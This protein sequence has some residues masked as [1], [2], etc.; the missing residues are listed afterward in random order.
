MMK[1]RHPT[2]RV[3]RVLAGVALAMALVGAPA[4]SM[5]DEAAPAVAVDGTSDAAAHG[6]AH[7]DEAHG[8]E[9]HGDD[10]KKG[11]DPLVFGSAVI[12]FLLYLGLLTFVFRKP[13]AK[14]FADRRGAIASE[15]EAARA[16]REEAEA[17]LTE[18]KKKLADFDAERTRLLTEFRELGEQ[19][20]LRIVAEGEAEAARI[21]RDATLAAENDVR[22]AKAALESQM[23]DLALQLAERELAA[24]LDAPTHGKLIDDGIEAI[25]QSAQG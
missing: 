19:E 22:R 15:M 13:A 5:A 3:L 14:F 24:R 11:L 6:D 18:T 25:T 2:S 9:A 20:R 4:V 17:A 21:V 10:Y 23:V 1:F 8:D 16:A 12:N 7:G